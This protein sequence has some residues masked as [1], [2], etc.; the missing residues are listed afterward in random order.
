MACYRVPNPDGTVVACGR[1]VITVRA[2]SDRVDQL[3]VAVEAQCGELRVRPGIRPE[4]TG[5]QKSSF[6]G[7]IAVLPRKAPRRMSYRRLLR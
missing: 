5:L 7:V 1:N 3:G 2:G 6:S 4:V